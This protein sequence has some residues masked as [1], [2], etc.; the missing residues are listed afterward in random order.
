MTWEAAI[1][2]AAR[3]LTEVNLGSSK[4]AICHCDGVFGVISGRL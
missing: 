1:D 3:Q 4:L 2:F